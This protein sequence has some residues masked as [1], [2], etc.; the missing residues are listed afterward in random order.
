MQNR[1]LVGLIAGLCI[2]ALLVGIKIGAARSRPKMVN[3]GMEIQVFDGHNRPLQ[4]DGG[5]RIVIKEFGQTRWPEA[6][7]AQIQGQPDPAGTLKTDARFP[8]DEEF[9]RNL[10][11]RAKSLE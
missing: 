2:S 4:P 10:A 8:L 5:I 9:I 6:L 7:W 1:K 11:K 3:I